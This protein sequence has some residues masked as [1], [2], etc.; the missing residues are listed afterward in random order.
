MSQSF[1]KPIGDQVR[2]NEMTGVL[3]NNNKA[4]NPKAPNI[5]GECTI[6][7]KVYEIAGWR[8]TSKAGNTYYS[9]KFQEPW[10]GNNGSMDEDEQLFP[11]PEDL[12]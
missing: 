6:G 4:T 9:L 3:F 11:L 8:N 2:D 12:A 1:D 7:G 10:K 5:K